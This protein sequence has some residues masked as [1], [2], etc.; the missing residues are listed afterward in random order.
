MKR[1]VEAGRVGDLDEIHVY[2]G[3]PSSAHQ[4]NSAARNK[5][6]AAEWTR[7]RRVTMHSRPL[8]YPW[9]WPVDK[10][11]EK[12]V[13][14]MLACDLI[15]CALDRRAGTLIVASRDT[16]LLPALEMAVKRGA[17]VE[18]VTWKGC[19]RLR[20]PSGLLWCTYLN[21]ADYLASKDPRQY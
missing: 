1:R 14:V 19:S 7:D 13:D 2:R 10:A 8:R 5:A 16:D 3:Q 9:N 11:R 15:E 6:Q 17:N 4:P 12:G 18:V 20:L 21:G